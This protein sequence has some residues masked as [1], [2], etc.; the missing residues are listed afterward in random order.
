MVNMQHVR[1][2]RLC[3]AGARVWLAHHGIELS[4]FLREGVPAEELEAT[5]DAFALHVAAIARKAAHG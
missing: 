3:S 1:A 5:G 2:A 4:R